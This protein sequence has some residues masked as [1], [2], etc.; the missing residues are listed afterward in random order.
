[1]RTVCLT[2]GMALLAATLSSGCSGSGVS[3]GSSFV[4]DPNAV[5]ETD[6]GDGPVAICEPT[7]DFVLSQVEMN[8]TFSPVTTSV[9]VDGTT[10]A[11]APSAMATLQPMTD[12]YFQLQF[13]AAVQVQP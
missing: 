6:A 1:M 7:C 9:S 13:G 5:G 10:I 3:D 12:G 4:V 2:V 11:M 8:P